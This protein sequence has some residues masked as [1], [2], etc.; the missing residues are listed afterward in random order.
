[1]HTGCIVQVVHGLTYFQLSMWSKGVQLV[2]QGENHIVD[3]LFV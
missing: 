3:G 2:V 1:M